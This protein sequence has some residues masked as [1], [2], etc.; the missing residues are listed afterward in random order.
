MKPE[1][2]EYYK[3]RIKYRGA[4]YDFIA[5]NPKIKERYQARRR[6][7]KKIIKRQMK[8]GALTFEMIEQKIYGITM[9]QEINIK[10]TKQIYKP[11]INDS[12]LYDYFRPKE[13]Q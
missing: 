12:T 9:Y 6:E 7:V 3:E 5:K 4:F 13:F 2:L 8:F 1:H 11:Q 10:Y